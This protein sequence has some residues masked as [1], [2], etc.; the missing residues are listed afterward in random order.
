MS[1]EETNYQRCV[2]NVLRA[3]AFFNLAG[4]T[5]YELINYHQV[6]SVYVYGIL[7]DLENEGR[8]VVRGERPTCRYEWRK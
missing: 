5:A 3:D 7:R 8:V 6:K 1:E 2:T 4:K